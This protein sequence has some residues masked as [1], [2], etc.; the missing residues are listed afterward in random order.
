MTARAAAIACLLAGGCSQ[1]FDPFALP[2]ATV[3]E[4][5]FVSL[6]EYPAARTRSL[7]LTEGEWQ[8]VP[9]IAGFIVDDTWFDDIVRQHH[10]RPVN[11]A[12]GVPIACRL[13]IESEV[14]YPINHEGP[15][16]YSTRVRMFRDRRY[17]YPCAAGRYLAFPLFIVSGVQVTERWEIQLTRSE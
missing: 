9:D 1:G 7:T 15:S 12:P 11:P 4:T 3:G 6:P 10:L 16:L 5:T 14:L 13:R 17:P 8:P 2:S